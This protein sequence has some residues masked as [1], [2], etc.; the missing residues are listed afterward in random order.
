MQCME[1]QRS[2]S[3]QSNKGCLQPSETTIFSI[4]SLF[5]KK[6]IYTNIL[7]LSLMCDLVQDIYRCIN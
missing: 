5:K 1:L 2:T 4:V 3:E 6:I 7:L